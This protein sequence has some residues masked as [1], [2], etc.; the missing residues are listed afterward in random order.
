MA[1][2]YELYSDGGFNSQIG[3]IVFDDDT[4]RCWID[5]LGTS[6]PLEI[7]AVEA[8]DHLSVTDQGQTATLGLV[9]GEMSLTAA[10][11]AGQ[12]GGL[13]NITGGTALMGMVELLSSVAVQ[14]SRAMAGKRH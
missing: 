2:R 14:Q 12:G 13:L 3:S 7:G 8:T 11:S 4:K 9:G 6:D 5:G 10:G 1:R